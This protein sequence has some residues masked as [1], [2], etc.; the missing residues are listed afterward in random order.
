MFSTKISNAFGFMP[1]RHLQIY[2]FVG[3]KLDTHW[4]V[5]PMITG[6]KKH[7]NLADSRK[8]TIKDN[9]LPCCTSSDLQYNTNSLLH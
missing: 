9:I 8:S 2:K 3:H 5:I 6:A 1:K 4:Y 7:L